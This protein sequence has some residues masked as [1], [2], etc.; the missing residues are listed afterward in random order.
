MFAVIKTGGKQYKV[1]VN[2]VVKIEK[3]EVA[4]GGNVSFDTVLMLGS[5]TIEVGSPT[6]VGAS[7]VGELVEQTRGPKTISFKKRRRQNSKRKKGHRQHL[8]VVRIT[9]ILTGGAKA[10]PAKAAKV[11]K[12]AAETSAA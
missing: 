6:V 5:E 1:A 11:E 7:V 2:D 12:A 4:A 8:S 10:K 3:L 9:E